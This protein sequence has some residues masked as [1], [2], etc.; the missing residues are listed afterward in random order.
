MGLELRVQAESALC[1]LD[2]QATVTYVVR[3]VGNLRD[4]VEVV[5]TR[6]V[7]LGEGE[8]DRVGLEAVDLR[9]A[10][11]DLIDQTF[12]SNTTLI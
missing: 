3:V 8:G 9:V 4:L 6:A 7:H 2:R 5:H 11:L 1:D 10:S 12:R